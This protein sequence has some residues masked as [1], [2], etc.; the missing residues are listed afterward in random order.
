[1]H[2]LNVGS[3]KDIFLWYRKDSFDH[4]IFGVMNGE[5]IGS[6]MNNSSGGKI[7]SVLEIYFF[8]FLNNQNINRFKMIINFFFLFSFFLTQSSFLL[9][10]QIR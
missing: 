9:L 2:N 8:N 3:G 6:S 5:T 7:Y 4:E 1:M 10:L